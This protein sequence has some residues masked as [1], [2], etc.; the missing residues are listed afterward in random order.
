MPVPNGSRPCRSEARELPSAAAWIWKRDDVPLSKAQKDAVWAALGIR[1]VPRNC[2]GCKR[3]TWTH[4][5]NL[6]LFQQLATD[7]SLPL[8]TGQPCVSPHCD[9]CAKMQSFNLIMLD[10]GG[11]FG[12]PAIDDET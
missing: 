11:L 12:M 10:L 3:N 2:P 1:G 6:T 7:N 9:N 4:S 8:G 5:K